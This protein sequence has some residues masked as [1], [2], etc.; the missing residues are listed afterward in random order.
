MWCALNINNVGLFQLFIQLFKGFK[1]GLYRKL[2]PETSPH[3]LSGEQMSL[4]CEC[5]GVI[6]H[7]RSL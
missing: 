4:V 7:A 1:V 5:E 6:Q 3:N 2:L